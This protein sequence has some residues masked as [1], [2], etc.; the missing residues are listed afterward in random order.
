MKVFCYRLSC[1]SIQ[2]RE[3]KKVHL[4]SRARLFRFWDIKTQKKT[5]YEALKGFHRLVCSQVDFLQL[6]FALVRAYKKDI[7]TPVRVVGFQ[8]RPS[9]LSLSDNNFFHSTR[10]SKFRNGFSFKCS[11]SYC[12]SFQGL[13]C[14]FSLSSP[15]MK[16][17]RR[18]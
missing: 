5:F 9:L 12:F 15:Q 6:Q 10:Y 7:T 14:S 3:S 8:F 13:Q 1:V 2:F 17:H 4:N 16:T 18:R 11:E